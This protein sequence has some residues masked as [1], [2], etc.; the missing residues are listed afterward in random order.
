MVVNWACH[1]AGMAS[2]MTGYSP[3]LPTLALHQV[4]SSRRWRGA[5]APCADAA[6]QARPTWMIEELRVRRHA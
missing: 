3:T 6:W 4:G 1:F 2:R 5:S